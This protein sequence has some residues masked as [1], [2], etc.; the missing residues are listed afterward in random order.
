MTGEQLYRQAFL[1]FWRGA[2]AIPNK[3]NASHCVTQDRCN[4]PWSNLTQNS[5]TKWQ[6]SIA[7]FS[8]S[9]IWSSC[10]FKGIQDAI[11]RGAVTQNNAISPTELLLSI[12]HLKYCRVQHVFMWILKSRSDHC[13][14]KLILDGWN[15]RGETSSVSLALICST[16]H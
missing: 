14:I 13:V 11:G 10:S 16:T 15:Q 12:Q 7:I 2:S 3:P 6:K 4:T 5:Q 1:I 9:C 8:F